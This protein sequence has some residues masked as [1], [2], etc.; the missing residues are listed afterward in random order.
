MGGR[1]LVKDDPAASDLYV[2]RSELKIIRL[3][4]KGMTSK[5][6]ALVRN[7]SHHTVET[8]R[9]NVLGRLQCRNTAQLIDLLHRNKILSEDGDTIA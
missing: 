6:I 4:A 9:H 1:I 5:E 8:H 7:V 2:S 3:L